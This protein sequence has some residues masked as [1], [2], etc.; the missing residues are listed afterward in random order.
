ML[1]TMP[2]AV[3]PLQTVMREG[4]PMHARGALRQYCER[5]EAT[6]RGDA[7]AELKRRHPQEFAP[8]N[9]F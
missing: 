2:C 7:V 6:G 1:A 5:L 9:L 4:G 3:D 8:Y